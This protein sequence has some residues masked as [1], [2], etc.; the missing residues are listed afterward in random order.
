MAEAMIKSPRSARV[1]IV[2]GGIIGC[3]TAWFLLEQGLDGEI[4][5][6][7]RDSSYRQSSTALSAASIRAQF[8]CRVNI[9][10]SLFGMAFLRDTRRRWPDADI[11]L[12]ERGY[13]ILGK[14]DQVDAR[15]EAMELQRGAG[16]R[17]IELGLDEL[18]SRFPWLSLDGVAIATLGEGEGWFDAWGLLQATRRAVLQRGA[19]F[20]SGEVC[21]VKVVGSHVASVRLHD[22]EVLAADWCVN[23]AGALSGKIA[24]MVGYP[25]PLVPKKRTVFHFKAP[26]AAPEIPMLFD[27][28]A[29]W[30]RPE[31]DGF[32]GGIAPNPMQDPNA[33]GDFEPQHALFEEDLW[34]ALAARVPVLEQVKLLRSWAGHYDM[35]L[36]DHNAFV[37]PHPDVPNFL[38]A[39][40]FSGHGVMHAPGAGRAV[41]EWI[42]AGGYRSIDLSGLR[43]ERFRENR[44]M[45][46]DSIY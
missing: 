37:G 21:D 38:F 12:T 4:I 14:A 43:V 44:P 13:L 15:R 25:L 5:V 29:A 18:R 39:C 7:E 31:G 33:Y 9:E 16:A 35:N 6:V 24:T 3:M 10:L 34:P 19:R 32:I 26:L 17:V 22:G 41:A 30:M 8:G 11:G 45:V 1:I 20:V 23:A 27:L 2:G 28:S 40:G 36:F 42:T 46:E